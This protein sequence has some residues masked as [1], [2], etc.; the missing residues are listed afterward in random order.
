[1]PPGTGKTYTGSRV[2]ARLV[3]EHGYRIGVVAQSH[4][5]VEEMLERIVAEGVPPGQVAK[6]PKKVS[7][8]ESYTVIR[9]DGMAGFLAERARQGAVVGGTAWD[10]S[11]PRRVERGEL[12]LLVIDEA[13][14]F[15]LAATI[16]VAA[17]A[18][19]LLL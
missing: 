15:S 17:G 14:Q 4:A 6:A 9:K 3:N 19:R 13:G 2:I 10:F 1:G 18:Q 16:A 12:D 11:N 8:R 5:I 7:G